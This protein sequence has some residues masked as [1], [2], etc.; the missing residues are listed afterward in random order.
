M[1]VN[2]SALLN[3]PR[4]KKK[5]TV[6]LTSASMPR[7]S[8]T[9]I[10]TLENRNR[11]CSRDVRLRRLVVLGHIS[12]PQLIERVCGTVEFVFTSIVALAFIARDDSWA[13]VHGGA[14]LQRRGRVDFP[15]FARLE[16]PTSLAPPAE[17]DVTEVPVTFRVSIA[18]FLVTNAAADRLTGRGRRVGRW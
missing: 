17:V 13:P 18:R 1:E 10:A 2:V 7:L 8:R 12:N 5:H 4:W 3:L 14:L 15:A 16:E 11:G 9:S 6:S